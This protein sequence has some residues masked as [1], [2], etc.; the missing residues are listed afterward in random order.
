MKQ[1]TIDKTAFLA[2]V[3]D[4]VIIGMKDKCDCI[5]IE[6]ENESDGQHL[7]IY[8]CKNNSGIGQVIEKYRHPFYALQKK[9]IDSIK[10]E[11][12][13]KKIVMSQKEDFGEWVRYIQIELPKTN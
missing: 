12:N 13:L 2:Y 4:A 11:M 8:F 5:R 9:D 6:D 10:K 1:Q 7:T 3:K